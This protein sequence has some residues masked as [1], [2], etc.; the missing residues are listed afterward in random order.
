M[1]KVREKLSIEFRPV[2]LY[3]DD[4]Y[5]IYKIFNK[6][7]KKVT[8]NADGME[9]EEREGINDFIDSIL[10]EEFTNISNLDIQGHSP[11]I[12]LT[13][14]KYSTELYAKNNL[15]K[16]KEIFEE[17]REILKPRQTSNFNIQSN[18]GFYIYMAIFFIAIYI[19]TYSVN[20]DLHIV[21]I[22]IVFLI[23]VFLSKQM[24]NKHKVLHL[25]K[26][27][28]DTKLS[29]KC[30]KKPTICMIIAIIVIAIIGAIFT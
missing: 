17:L 26:E 8:I 24:T 25:N 15:A 10:K 29:N 14:T 1:K 16:D 23:V 9:L 28:K 22:F 13:L 7:C 2:T 11:D 4:F 19:T 6:E 12:S 21:L 20:K 30:E 27:Y 3:R 5:K 18:V